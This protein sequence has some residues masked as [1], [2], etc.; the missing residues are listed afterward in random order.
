MLIAQKVIHEIYLLPKEEKEKLALHAREGWSRSLRQD[1]SSLHQLRI[2]C[3][4]VFQQFENAQAVP[5]TERNSLGL[6]DQRSCRLYR[7]SDDKI[8][9][10]GLLQGDCT[11]E[12]RLVIG[13]DSQR[14]SAIVFDKNLGHVHTLSL[15]YTFKMYDTSHAMAREYQRYILQ[16]YFANFP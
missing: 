10:S 15:L 9:E 2:R 1:V 11:H 12:K 8:G 5:F 13:R 7:M 6:I 4:R 16:P 3:R 14:H